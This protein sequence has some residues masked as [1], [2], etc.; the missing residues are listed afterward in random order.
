MPKEKQTSRRSILHIALN[1]LNP[2]DVL[3]VVK[4][5]DGFY[6]SVEQGKPNEFVAET[7]LRTSQQYF[8]TKVK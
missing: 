3:I 4:D 1:R 5:S 8:E 7:I 2:G 6:H